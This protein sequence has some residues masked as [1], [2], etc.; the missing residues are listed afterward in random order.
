[1]KRLIMRPCLRGLLFVC[2]LA[3]G[4]HAAARSADH[5]PTISQPGLVVISSAEKGWTARITLQDYLQEYVFPEELISYKVVFPPRAVRPEHLRLTAERTGAPVCYQLAD[6]KQSE[7]FLAS[8]T[9]RFRASLGKGETKS[10]VLGSDPSYRAEFAKGVVLRDVDLQAHTAV[11][12]ANTQQVKVPYGE[13]APH[14]RISTVQAP[15]LWL[16]RTYG[17]WI[18]RGWFTGPA[19]VEKVRTSVVEEGPLRLVYRIDYALAGGK[20][21]AVV[22]T[23]QAGDTFITVDEYLRGLGQKDQLAFNF[24]YRDGIDPD[25]RLAPSNMG[26]LPERSGR[27]DAGVTDGKL[28]YALGIFGPNVACPRT[29]LF[30]RND[31]AD[32][33]AIAFSLYRLQDWKTHIRY[34]WNATSAAENLW[35]YHGTDKYMS[36][37]LLGQERHWAVSIL[38][39]REVAVQSQ[40]GSK[41][42][43]WYADNEMRGYDR[44]L[45]GGPH[46]GDPSVRLFQR[47]GGL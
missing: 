14:A 24:S 17:S 21:Y 36:V 34:V 22:M 26:L 20:S 32:S 47:L 29:T 7:G 11:L 2:C 43:Y 8:V 18:G 9:I 15:I 46:G 35:F 40:D 27:Y 5:P 16:S 13:F 30:F 6:V 45:R 28:P 33:D 37:H 42:V 3:A 41:K 12:D 23:A 19:I 10:F 39:R 38:P 25:G 44:N 1:M 31:V 4:F